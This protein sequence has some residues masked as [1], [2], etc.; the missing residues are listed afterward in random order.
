MRFFKDF[1][2]LNLEDY[3]NFGIR[4]P[5]GMFLIFLSVAMCAAYFII[6]YRNIYMVTLLKKLIRHNATSEE[7]AITLGEIGLSKNRP[8]CRALSRSGQLTFIVKQKGAVETTYEEYTKKLKTKNFKDAKIDFRLAEFY[9]SP[10]RIDRAQKMV[11]TNST[12]WV[13]PIVLSGITLALLFLFAIFSPEIL[14][15]I[16]NYFS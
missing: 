8:L 9:I 4:F 13:K 1:F 15:A 16:N 14:T 12:S 6:T 11:E 5:L 7:C 3:D 2:F 10:D